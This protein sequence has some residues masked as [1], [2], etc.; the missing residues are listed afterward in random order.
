MFGVCSGTSLFARFLEGA[1]NH[2][3]FMLLYFPLQLLL[4]CIG[5]NLLY[6]SSS[7]WN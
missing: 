2:L 4:Q 1:F 7:L 3:L 5:W 6:L